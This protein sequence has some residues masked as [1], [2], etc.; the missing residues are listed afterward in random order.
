MTVPTVGTDTE[1][2]NSGAS[3]TPFSFSHTVA[4]GTSKLVVVVDIC[5]DKNDP[6]TVDSVVW[7]SAGVNESLT[8][9]VDL[10][11]A[12]K[13]SSRVTIWTLDS[14]T[15]KT[16]NITVT[17][18]SDIS[19]AQG[20]NAIN[21]SDTDT[22]V[23]G[24]TTQDNSSVG[25]DYTMS[26]TRVGSGDGILIY[27]SCCYAGDVW[28]LTP[29]TGD[30]EIMDAQTGTS[31]KADLTIWTTYETHTTGGSKTL[32]GTGGNGSGAL[33]ILEIAGAA[34]T[35]TEIIPPAAQLQV[36]AGAASFD[37]GILPPSAQLEIST[38]IPA[39]A[40]G[41]LR[42]PPAAQ[43][44]LSTAIPALPIGYRATAQVGNSFQ[45]TN[46]THLFERTASPAA[47]LGLFQDDTGSDWGLWAKDGADPISGAEGGWSLEAL[48]GG[49][50]VYVDG[51]NT[52][53]LD[54][55]W[56][57]AN[58]RLHVLAFHPSVP[59]YDEWD[60]N[61]G[62][63]DWTNSVANEA[64]GVP[65]AALT[66]V[67]NMRGSIGVDASGVPWIAFYD[68][69]DNLLKVRSRTGGT[70]GN[71]VTIEATASTTT[72]VR[73][74][75]NRWSDDA[76]AAGM[77][78]LYNWGISGGDEWRFAYRK[79]TDAV[80][81]SWTTETANN[82]ITD[83][84][85][86]SMQTLKLGADTTSTI[87]AA[88]KDVGD[89]IY[90]L[91][92]NS[93]GT[94]SATSA[95]RNNATRPGLCLDGENEDVYVFWPDSTGSTGTSVNYR[96]GDI[97]TL[98]FDAEQKILSL[99]G[100]ATFS[101]NL[102]VQHLPATDASDLYVLSQ[103]G[104]DVWWNRIEI[105]ASLD[106]EIS[107]PA[108][109]LQISTTAPSLDIGLRPPAAQ[110]QLTTTAPVLTPGIARQPD[111]ANLQIT[112]T[113]PDSVVD[114]RREPA[115]AQLEISTAA[116]ALSVGIA[117]EVP[118]ANLQITTTAPT[119]VVSENHAF[120]VPAAD[121]ELST[122]APAKQVDFRREPAAANLNLSTA[123]P[124]VS[125]GLGFGPPAAQIEIST[126][127]PERLID[128][129]R[130]PAAGQIE[131]STTVPTATTGFNLTPPAGQIEIST[132]APTVAVSDN[133]AIEI[134]AAQ[135]QLSTS[136]SERVLDIIRTPP[137]G[138]IQITTTAPTVSVFGGDVAVEPP[139]GQLELST[140]APIVAV[141]GQIVLPPRH[142]GLL[143]N[144]GQFL[145]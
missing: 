102:S 27:A 105:A 141:S 112:T 35:G 19:S 127:A 30:T 56:D 43:L 2:T 51:R 17:L 131:L 132:T 21:L 140:T 12:E 136:A 84:D 50:S 110:L 134:P 95:I 3:G 93:S 142:E 7:D 137:A 78:I 22:G 48:S 114:F 38:T 46:C 11:G 23:L 37:I 100:V 133:H 122:T 1:Y 73:I 99:D 5:D 116:S 36:S 120:T 135:L 98:T 13:T 63:N 123:V 89:E 115:A 74:D 34:D 26:H 40:T 29:N 96:K 31:N 119:V 10:L 130:E 52:S 16:A 32:G 83:D 58:S 68:T 54:T 97:A 87:V 49:G 70:W 77:C 103:S 125:V 111:A 138:Q 79:D 41:S 107:P 128:F 81:A 101:N 28:P 85:H 9:R 8:K 104:G 66:D 15:A 143:K 108:A 67:A 121:L 92:R 25:T 126:T 20:C 59:Q 117:R 75:I 6:G 57:D 91:K 69:T 109:Q 88:I 53:R 90:V 14:P 94:W 139:A 62:T 33:A 44:E 42:E 45:H 86:I 4:S 64:P 76:G 118:G 106:T 39:R 82:T 47:V 71:T 18:G 24:S 145:R 72:G 55:Y 144:I 80:T 65:G 124:A 61:T 129:R 60:F 113:A